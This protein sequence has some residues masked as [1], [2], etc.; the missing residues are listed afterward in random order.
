MHPQYSLLENRERETHPQVPCPSLV[1][2]PPCHGYKYKYGYWRQQPISALIL[3][4]HLQQPTL[5]TTVH[6]MK[7]RCVSTENS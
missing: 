5:Y 7:G 6:G 1:M 2:M 4:G 3:E